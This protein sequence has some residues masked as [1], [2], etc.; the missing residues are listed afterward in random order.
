VRLSADSHSRELGRTT[1]D[2]AGQADRIASL[3]PG[4]WC[5]N[6]L[7]AV[8]AYVLEADDGYVLVDCG[9]DT[10]D[11]LE[12]LKVGLR[13]LGIGLDD[14]RTLVVTH[15]HADHYGMAGTL[16][17]LG[18]MRL[19]M[20][21]L[22]WVYAD[23]RFRDLDRAELDIHAW[24]ARNGFQVPLRTAA[25]RAL[26]SLYRVTVIAP[27]REIED[28]DA[29]PLRDSA[30][31]VVWTPGHTQGHVCLHAPERRFLLAGDHVL[32]PITPNVSMNFE[33]IHNP[34]GRY[35]HSLRKAAELEADIVLPAH[36]S[37]FTGLQRR[38]RELLAHHDDREAAVLD[39]LRGIP[40]TAGDVARLLPWTRR[41]RRFEEL[42]PSPSRSRTRPGRSGSPARAATFPAPRTSRQRSSWRVGTRSRTTAT[43]SRRCE[44]RWETRC[45]Q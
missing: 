41:G 1:T 33:D 26:D 14:V 43:T 16:L 11:V 23:R 30:C 36:G 21:R 10:P 17:R 25:E 19:L 9:W 39:A 38:V 4:V 24:L 13:G 2:T 40:R 34:L 31:Q 15:V 45:R 7:R 29:I 6:P 37:P 27:D 42:A 3:P 22:D 35:V 44:R 18:R 20:H 28:G 12:A 5:I 32:D 8:N